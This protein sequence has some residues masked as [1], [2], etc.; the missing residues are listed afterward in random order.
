MIYHLLLSACLI[1]N[2]YIV[3]KLT[4]V[5]LDHHRRIDA[6][7]AEAARRRYTFP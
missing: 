4:R 2:A 7:E 1:F 3:Y 5:G 6:L